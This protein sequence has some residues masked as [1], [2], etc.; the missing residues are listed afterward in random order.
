[1][2]FS[3]FAK[4]HINELAGHPGRD[5]TLATEKSIS[6]IHKCTDSQTR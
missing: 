1:M 2:I 4:A 3:V 5:R 6:S